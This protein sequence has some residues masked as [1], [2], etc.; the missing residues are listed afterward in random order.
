MERYLDA[1]DHTLA[2]DVPAPPEPP[3]RVLGALGPRMLELARDRAN[4]AHP[5]F[6]PPETLPMLARCWGRGDCCV[7]SRWSS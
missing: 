7:P 1:I 5:F 3:L 2:G 4:G 6:V